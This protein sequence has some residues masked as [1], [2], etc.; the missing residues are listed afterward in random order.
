MGL[1]EEAKHKEQSRQIEKDKR[2]KREEIEAKKKI[3][4]Q[5]EADK[6][7]RKEKV[8]RTPHPSCP[9]ITPC[10]KYKDR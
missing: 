8:P 3:K 9:L 5:I 7:A 4:E 1:F 6:Q 2:L 10:S